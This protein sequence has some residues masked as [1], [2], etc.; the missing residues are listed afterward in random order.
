MCDFWQVPSLRSYTACFQRPAKETSDWFSFLFH[1]FVSLSPGWQIYTVA[2][3]NLQANSSREAQVGAFAAGNECAELSVI[4]CWA[5]NVNSVSCWWAYGCQ[6]VDL[7]IEYWNPTLLNVVLWE[8]KI[9]KEFIDSERTG[10][11]T[12]WIYYLTF[13]LSVKYV[14]RRRE[15]LLP[16]WFPECLTRT[17]SLC[18]I[19][20]PSFSLCCGHRRLSF[21]LYIVLC[22]KCVNVMIL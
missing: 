16:K 17:N 14:H 21:S 3:L 6:I 9:R 5:L 8:W 18:K 1:L 7:F 11:Q 19:G 4:F 12:M 2:L 10:Q 22:R 15:A 20:A 13:E